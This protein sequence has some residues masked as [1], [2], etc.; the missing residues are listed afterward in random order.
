MYAIVDSQQTLLV[1]GRVNKDTNSI[2]VC[3]LLFEA[4]LQAPRLPDMRLCWFAWVRSIESVHASFPW[5]GADCTREVCALGGSLTVYSRA[6][7]AEQTSS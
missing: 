6:S 3:F 4:W 2:L 7:Q 5:R 1:H